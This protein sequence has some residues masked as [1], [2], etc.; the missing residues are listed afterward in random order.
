MFLVMTCA[1]IACGILTYQIQR[2]KRQVI[3]VR[4]IEALGGV[5]LRT[6]LREGIFYSGGKLPEPRFK[7]LHSILGEE[8]FTYV[9]MIDIRDPSVTADDIRAMIPNLEQI[10]LVEGLNQAGKT[11]I[12]LFDIG[13]PN[14]DDD[15]IEYLSRRLP[16]CV[17]TSTLVGTPAINV[18]N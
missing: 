14:V 4:Q 16:Q 3:A 7:W 2:A 10:R 15:L 6:T 9:P 17:F 8:Y 11:N 18:A 13:N 5:P 12:A 1:A